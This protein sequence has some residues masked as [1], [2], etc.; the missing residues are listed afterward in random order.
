MTEAV[1][2]LLLLLLRTAGSPHSSMGAA[3]APRFRAS[4]LKRR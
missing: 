4:V 1:L 2:L 3:V